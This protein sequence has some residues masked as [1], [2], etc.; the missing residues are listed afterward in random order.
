MGVANT[1]LAPVR[2]RTA[3]GLIVHGGGLV[4]NGRV[5]Q[6]VGVEYGRSFTAGG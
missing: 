1:P 5:Q 6:Y 2:N 4:L 3:H